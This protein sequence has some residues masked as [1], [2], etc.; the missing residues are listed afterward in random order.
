M[1]WRFRLAALGAVALF[2]ARVSAGE[3]PLV[4]WAMGEEGKKIAEVARRFERDNPGLKVET[5][6]IPWEAAHAKLL[7]AVVGGI[8]PDVSQVGTT[9]MAEFAAMGALEPLDDRAAGGRGRAGRR[10]G[11][12]SG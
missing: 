10:R 5:Q 4:V 7:T 8:P 1:F 2:S 12:R 3:R 11:A 9:W 6:A